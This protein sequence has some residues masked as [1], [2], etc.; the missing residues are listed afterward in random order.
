VIGTAAFL[1]GDGVADL[2]ET[3]T[4]PA[5]Q[6]LSNGPALT[7]LRRLQN[8]LITDSRAGTHRPPVTAQTLAAG[9]RHVGAGSCARSS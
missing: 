9:V 2:P 1:L 3:G 4:V 7:T 5:Y 6:R 8:Q